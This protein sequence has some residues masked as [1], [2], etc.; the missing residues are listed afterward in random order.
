MWYNA[1]M[2]ITR[3]AFAMALVFPPAR[4]AAEQ[5]QIVSCQNVPERP[6]ATLE[7]VAACG[8]S[9]IRLYSTPLSYEVAGKNGKILVKRTEIGLVLD[10]KSIDRD[11]KCI[12]A[13]SSTLGG[14]LNTPVY[15]KSRINLAGTETVADFGDYAVRLVARPDGVAYRFELRRGATIDG[16]TASVTIPP[17]AKCAFNRNMRSF[18]GCEE[19]L[20]EFADAGA[21]DNGEKRHIYLPFVFE[22]DGTTVAVADADV[23]DYPVWN[24]GDVRKTA[25]G[26]VAFDAFFAKYPDRKE[27]CEGWGNEQLLETGGRWIKVRSTKDYLVKAAEARLLPWRVFVIADAPAKLCESDIIYALSAP[28]REGWDFSWVK[29]GKVAW[30][31]WNSFDN[32][33][34]KGCNTATYRRFVD[35]AAKHGVEY[36]ILDEGWSEHLNIWKFRDDVDVP[37][38]VEYANSKGVGIILWMAWAQIA[39]E[40]E[41]VAEHFEKMGVKGFKIDFMDR[42]D[43]EMASFLE[44]CAEAC[45]RHKL[46]VDYHGV[47]RPT[48]LQRRWPNIVNYEGIHGLEQL[49]WARPE[50]DMVYNDV[51]A[52]FLRMTA[53]PMDYTPGAM[54]NYPV[55]AYKGNG[56]NPG[57]VGTRCHQIALMVLYEAPLQ[58]LCDSPTKYEKNLE[59]F[60]FMAAVPTVWDETIGLAGTPRTMA[61]V[62]RK[63]KDGAWYA[64]GITDNTARDFTLDTSFLGEGRWRAEIFRDHAAC[65]MKP[66]CFMHGSTSVAAGEKLSLPMARG[67]GFAVRFWKVQ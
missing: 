6:A 63:A 7:A 47:Y 33:G 36:V 45:A 5:N 22:Y 51:A 25:G 3:I 15:K 12:R 48:G 62:A 27:H 16:E 46:I 21:I 8:D 30:D 26:D 32:Q 43:A 52:F 53:G 38:I 35:F 55:G 13:E 49:R 31:W 20:P 64:A 37:G 28:A 60:R 58:M 18:V 14:F 66:E 61:A 54:D 65:D 59:C 39:G 19:T 57:S 29:P 9:E 1:R 34:G 56:L 2:D 4:L 17:E 10:G 50:K 67:G 44:T 23:R 24:L 40:E 42:G 11:S 41:K